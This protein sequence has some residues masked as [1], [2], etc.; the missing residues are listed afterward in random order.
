MGPSMAPHYAGEAFPHRKQRRNSQE[1]QVC[2]TIATPASF[3]RTKAGV[4]ANVH[5]LLAV[6]QFA[7]GQFAVKKMVVSVSLG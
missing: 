7:V 6:G 4:S 2:H 1:S 3:G 5:E